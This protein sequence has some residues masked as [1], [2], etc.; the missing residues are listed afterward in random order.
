MITEDNL[1]AALL[2]AIV[3]GLIWFGWQIRKGWQSFLLSLN[4]K[5]GKKGEAAAIK[6]L[7]KAGFK[8]IDDQMSLDGT[9]HVDGRMVHYQVRPDFL[10]SRDGNTFVA[11]VKTGDATKISDRNTRR[12]LREYASLKGNGKVLLVDGQKGTISEII[13]D[14]EV[15]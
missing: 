8:I 4:R 10:V 2:I 9:L 13:F 15:V 14:D 5:K 6:A 12:Q 1:T 3:L 11:E 7:K